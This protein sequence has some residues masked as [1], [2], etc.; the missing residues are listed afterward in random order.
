M[1]V[2]KYFR[3]AVAAHMCPCVNFKDEKFIKIG[4]EQ[5]ETGK[6]LQN[7]TDYLFNENMIDKQKE[8]VSILIS[9]KTLATDINNSVKNSTS[10]EE[11]TGVFFMPALLNRDG[12]L[13]PCKEKKPWFAREYLYPMIDEEICIGYEKDLDNYISSSV[14]EYQKIESW[15]DSLDYTSLMFEAVT[16]CKLTSDT[17]GIDKNIAT[18]N[19]CYLFFDNTVIASHNILKLYD[20]IINN[21]PTSIPLYERFISSSLTPQ[22]AT[23]KNTV[24]NMKQHSGQ[25]GGEYPLS[26]SQRRCIN[27][28]NNMESSEI[29]AVSGPPGT[30]K[31]TLLQSAVADLLT[32]HA[33]KAIDPPIIVASSTNNQA[34]T[35]I[36]DSF[37]AIKSLGIGN[38]EKRWITVT[39]S[40]ATYFPSSSKISNAKSKKYQINEELIIKLN[41]GD[42]KDKSE[43]CMLK[44]SS[45]YFSDSVNSISVCKSKIH[46]RLLEINDLKNALISN[47]DNL[48]QKTN[49]Q[50]VQNYLENLQQKIKDIDSKISNTQNIIQTKNE[51]TEKYQNRIA[52]WK[53]K[54]KQLPIYVRLFSFI[55]I[56]KKQIIAWI[57]NNKNEYELLNLYSTNTIKGITNHYKG[58]IESTENEIYNL[59]SNIAHFN[60]EKERLDCE[61]K[62]IDNELSLVTETA[63]KLKSKTKPSTSDNI[64]TIKEIISKYAIYDLNEKIDTSVRYI[65]FWLAVHYYECIWLETKNLTDKQLSTNIKDIQIHKLRDFS[66]I[67]P[68]MVMTFYMLP[69]TF[70]I[71][72]QNEKVADYLYNHIDL[73]IVDEAG[74]T[75]PEIA[76]PSFA[77]A[78]RAIV[79]GDEQQIPPVWGTHRALDLTL[80]IHNGVINNENDFN[81]LI[82]SGLNTSQSSVMKVAIHSCPYGANNDRGMFLSEHRRCY[83][84]IISYCNELVYKGK[85]E[86]L[87]GKGGKDK[88]RVL[89]IDKYPVMGYFDIPTDSTLTVGTSR[90]NY[91]EAETIALWIAEHFTEINNYYKSIDAS[92]S[93]KSILAIITPFRAQAVLIREELEKKAKGICKYID[94]GTVHTFQGG[95]RKV[96]IF[97][98]TYSKNDSCHFINSNKNLMN[99]A[100]SRAKDAFWVFGSYDCLKKAPERSASGLLAKYINYR[101]I[102]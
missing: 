1:S 24:H 63:I 69:K 48:L 5:I 35:N 97:S 20:N 89:P 13:Y 28:L 92:V 16:K 53:T 7:D 81:I 50:P 96:I 10:S 30:G 12:T 71:W 31:T 49:G 72:K 33:I 55:T 37:G 51:Q 59:R 80:A 94:V 87:R 74:Q 14:A 8:S 86:P 29:L 40:F 18:E 88:C 85:L 46:N 66:L 60:K 82:E 57:K 38:I 41:S 79:V 43:K 70:E 67:T 56:F 22:K 52:E 3:N 73:L 54:Y 65:E 25:M 45:K 83:D 44:E 58:L 90:V 62:A 98:T 15:N 21:P 32:K 9:L 2:T 78:K 47:F 95:E 102:K 27:Q 42:E 100:V 36:I 6:L 84:E 99:V 75:S 23:S 61:Y 4:F 26:P 76:A 91:K 93:T 19:C 64:D 77:L 11:L 39:E 17:I 34:V 68:C 101:I